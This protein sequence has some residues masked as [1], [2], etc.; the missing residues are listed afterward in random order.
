MW[1]CL[2]HKNLV[3]FVFSTLPGSSFFCL[4][5]EYPTDPERVELVPTPMEIC[6]G[7]VSRLSDCDL[8]AGLVLAV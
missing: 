5:M 3:D 8:E 1:S 4:A 2:C 7:N 6:R